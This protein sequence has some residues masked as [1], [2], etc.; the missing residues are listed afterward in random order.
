M[1]RGFFF[2]TGGGKNKGKVSL[3]SRRSEENEGGDEVGNGKGKII[4]IQVTGRKRLITRED[5]R[6][7]GVSKETKQ[8]GRVFTPTTARK[9]KGKENRYRDPR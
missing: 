9:K 3:N 5:L 4:T 2:E 1:G 7:R 6:K 8:K